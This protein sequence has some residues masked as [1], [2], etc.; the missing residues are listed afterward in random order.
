ML[1]SI[2]STP[3]SCS[4]RTERT[5][6]ANSGTSASGRP[7]AGSSRSTNAARSRARARRRAAARRRARA[8]PRAASAS[9]QSR[10]ARA[11]RPPARARAGRAPTPS[12]ATSTFSRTVRPRKERLCWNVR[13][14]PARPRRCGLQPV[15]SRPSSSTAAGRRPVEAGEHVHERRLARAVRADQPDHLVA[16]AARASRRRAPARPRTSATRRRPGAS[17]RASATFRDVGKSAVRQIL[18]T[19]LAVTAPTSFGLLF[20]IRSRGTAVRTPCGAAA[21]S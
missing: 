1:W 19:T 20:W 5:T 18:G 15:T 12:A 14:S 21:R 8:R 2:R 7:A 16:V 9:G 10:A 17:L 11:A 13:A 6:A 4:S 3:A